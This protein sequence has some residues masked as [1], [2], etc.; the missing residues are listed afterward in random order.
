[1]DDARRDRRRARDVGA[2][3]RAGAAGPLRRGHDDG[4]CGH[5]LQPGDP[6]SG[7]TSEHA[8]DACPQLQHYMLTASASN[9]LGPVI[10]GFPIDHSDH[11]T[12][13]L[14]LA[15][16]TLVPVLLLVT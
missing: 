11:A 14:Y 3:F 6:E 13:C 2:I 4:D 10:G 9:L 8:G 1:A 7:G 5:F 12:T 15:L 16:L